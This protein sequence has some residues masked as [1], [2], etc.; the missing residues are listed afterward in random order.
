MFGCNDQLAASP[1]ESEIQRLQVGVSHGGEVSAE[2]GEVRLGLYPTP[3]D[4]RES[5]VL[6]TTQKC[7]V[8]RK[9]Y[10]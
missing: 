7:Q 5:E 3:V 10:Q 4:S 1:V 9:I 8:N 2:S 6:P